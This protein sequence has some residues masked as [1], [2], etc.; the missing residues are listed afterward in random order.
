MPQYVPVDPEA[1]GC[2]LA[3]GLLVRYWRPIF[4]CLVVLALIIGA[5][6][7]VAGIINGSATVAKYGTADQRAIATIEAQRR[8]DELVSRLR[9]LGTIQVNQNNNNGRV[10]RVEFRN[11]QIIVYFESTSQVQEDACITWFN[12]DLYPK[13]PPLQK[14]VN[15]AGNR[16]TGYMTF[17]D[18]I[19]VPYTNFS[20]SYRCGSALWPSIELWS[21]NFT[22]SLIR[23]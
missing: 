1:Y 19:I 17:T 3:I 6:G 2:G 16:V 13:S 14:Q 5:L 10:D 11:E 4:A 8:K 23:R 20:F 12:G 15:V 21:A 18:S 7:L 9:Q 22:N